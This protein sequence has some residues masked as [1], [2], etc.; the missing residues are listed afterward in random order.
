MIFY[1]ADLHLGHENVIAYSKRAFE[2]CAEMLD[3]I[4]QNWNSVA[5]DNDEV[6]II[7]DLFF[8]INST[9]QLGSSAVYPGIEAF[10]VKR[11]ETV[12]V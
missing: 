12:T 6:Y 9:E 10:N 4:I 11:K 2:N 8:K 5:T 1:T 7:G 3:V